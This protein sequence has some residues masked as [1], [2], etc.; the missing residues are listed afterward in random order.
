MKQAICIIL[1]LTIAFQ[2]NDISGTYSYGDGYG[3]EFMTLSADKEVTVSQF[4]DGGGRSRKRTIATYTVAG[5]SLKLNYL[6]PKWEKRYSERFGY[7][8]IIREHEDF[9]A[10]LPPAEAANWETHLAGY[11]DLKKKVRGKIPDSV[12]SKFFSS[13]KIYVLVK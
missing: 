9:R 5:D 11:E 4:T 2:E 8:F 1:L 10:L 7:F 13:Y 6:A 12:K 3:F